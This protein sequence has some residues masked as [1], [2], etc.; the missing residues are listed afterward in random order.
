MGGSEVYLLMYPGQVRQSK[1]L[2]KNDLS[3]DQVLSF[4][5]VGS[6]CGFVI[7]DKTGVKISGGGEEVVTATISL[8]KNVIYDSTYGFDIIVS[9]YSGHS[10]VVKST[11]SVS[12]FS[13]WYSKFDLF[14]SKGDSGY[15]FSLGGFDVPKL[16]AY[17]LGV[18]LSLLVVF[19][20]FS[21]SSK[22][23][24]G[25]DWLVYFLVGFV[26]FVV[27]SVVF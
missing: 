18:G 20:V 26:V 7:L 13:S 15:W 19:I 10:S 24:K 5:C 1:F 9:D 23:K 2:L 11:I 14:V 27:L 17:V 6:G 8:P 3:V 21:A 12:K 25:G 22:G 16:L 4:K